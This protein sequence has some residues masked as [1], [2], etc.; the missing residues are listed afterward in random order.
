MKQ[1]PLI[2]SLLLAVATLSAAHGA[3]TIAFNAPFSGGMSSNFANSQ[4]VVS[5]GMKWGIVVDT[6][7]N[8]FLDSYD[9][10]ALVQGTSVALKAN[11]FATDDRLVL[12]LD[13]TSDSSQGGQAL[14]GDFLTPGGNGGIS[15]ISFALTNGMARGNTFF[16]VWFDE[17]SGRFGALGSPQFVIPADGQTVTYAQVFEG[18][19]PI[20]K[21]SNGYVPEPSSALLGLPGAF[22]LLRRRR[23]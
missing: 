18:V 7:G 5:N 1:H 12:A 17:T 16:L 14:E 8:S 3:V 13:L 22:G 20:R 10:V 19:D 2:V 15:G 11:G 6:T 23:R 4:G 21:A 9:S